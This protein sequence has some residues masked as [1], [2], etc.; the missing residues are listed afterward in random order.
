MASASVVFIASRGLVKA[1]DEIGERTGISRA[2]VGLLLLATATSL[3]EVFT[4]ASAVTLVGSVDIAAGDIFGSNLFNL[5]IIGLLDLSYRHQAILTSV[6]LSILRPTILSGLIIGLA[7]LFILLS[8]ADT[9]SLGWLLGLFTPAL[10]VVY[11]LSI[12]WLS[13]SDTAQAPE[14]TAVADAKSPPGLRGPLLLYGVSA[15]AIA[16]AGLGLSYAGEEIAELTGWGSSF[17]G[18]L[19]VAL[20]TSLPEVGTSFAAMRIGARDMAI[21]NMVGSNMFNTGVVPFTDDLFYRNGH[22]LGSFSSIHLITAL[23]T[24]GMTLVIIAGLLMR[25][26]GKVVG[27]VTPEVVALLAL[28]I[29]AHVLVF[30]YR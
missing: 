17:V 25:P 19:F 14:E 22:F 24:I 16:A 11:I 28:F 18:S 15:A 12:F 8:Q 20:S 5:M 21:A 9:L 6:D 30:I 3:P 1:G 10:L 23:I 27:T 7:G 2:F 29:L 4:G 13:R 26:R